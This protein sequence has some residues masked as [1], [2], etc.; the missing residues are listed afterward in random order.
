LMNNKENSISSRLGEL[1]S[2]LENVKRCELCD[3][4]VQNPR[5][6]CTVKGFDYVSCPEC[7][8]VFMHPR[9]AF[10][11]I[12][13][14]YKS[15]YYS[16]NVSKRPS[17]LQRIRDESLMD[18][19]GYPPRENPLWISALSKI[20]RLVRGFQTAIVLPY[21]G[22]SE[23]QPKFLDVGCGSGDFMIWAG[24]AGWEV[25]GV[26][27]GH[28]A[29]QNAQN[30]GLN[31]LEGTIENAGFPSAF[32]DAI[33][34]NNT[35]EHMHHPLSALRECRKIIKP[36]G[37]LIVCVPNFA[38]INARTFGKYWSLHSVPHH[39]FQFTPQTLEAMLKKVGFKVERWHYKSL[40]IPYT[41]KNTFRAFKA[42]IKSGEVDGG[43]QLYW[44]LR[45]KITL[46]LR[47]QVLLG[48]GNRQ[49]HAQFIT[50]YCRPK[51]V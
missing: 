50:A 29:V 48:L 37:L 17:I 24:Q 4:P 5:I 21:F 33:L 43:M 3:W 14:Y 45:L 41:E 39:L 25:K 18:L 2:N 30:R 19:G 23:S 40:F 9:P 16:Y 15:S 20:I 10:D 35:V 11:N 34:C 28:Q 49:D 46:L 1:S 27:I 36:E 47:L 44:K 22:K 38:G 51:N 8:L 6:V 12:G 32:F 42:G 13:H 31:V 7:G 26:E